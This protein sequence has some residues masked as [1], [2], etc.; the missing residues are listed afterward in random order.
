MATTKKPAG[1]L[2]SVQN[3]IKKALGIDEGVGSFGVF[4]SAVLVLFGAGLLVF[5]LIA[6]FGVGHTALAEA[7]KGRG[8]SVLG[9]LVLAITAAWAWL[10]FTDRIPFR[11]STMAFIISLLI[12]IILIV[13]IN[14][15]FFSKVY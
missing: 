10:N 11:V 6:S 1:V 4:L 8:S 13:N 7:S 3:F 2:T 14:T 12:L 15:G 9:V 5:L